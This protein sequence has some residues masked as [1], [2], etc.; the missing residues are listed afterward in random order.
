MWLEPLFKQQ[1]HTWFV[2][3]FSMS[4]LG[5]SW[6]TE[7]DRGLSGMVVFGVFIH[8]PMNIWSGNLDKKHGTVHPREVSSDR[9]YDRNLGYRAGIVERSGS[10]TSVG[11]FL[12]V[13]RAAVLPV[14]DIRVLPA[15]SPFLE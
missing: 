14:M 8:V 13:P 10:S 11:C 12:Q 2:G 1:H 9:K 4:G 7:K 6:N 15:A 3:C 5:T